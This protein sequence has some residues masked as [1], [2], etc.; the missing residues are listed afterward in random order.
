MLLWLECAH[1]SPG[2]LVK[3]LQQVCGGA[4]EGAPL[5]TSF[6]VTLPGAGFHTGQPR[7]R[8]LEIQSQASPPHASRFST[9]P[10]PTSQLSFAHLPLVF[11]SSPWNLCHSREMQESQRAG[12][13]SGLLMAA[14][15]LTCDEEGGIFS[16]HETGSGD[17]N[18]E[19]SHQLSNSI[20]NA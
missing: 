19:T 2:N 6:Q 9:G 18:S 10:R 11:L 13:W 3:M 15:I 4:W 8:G 7:T 14:Q 17:P 12:W 5:L 1:K 16:G 20:P